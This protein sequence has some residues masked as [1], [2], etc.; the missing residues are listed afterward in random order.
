[1]ITTGQEYVCTACGQHIIFQFEGEE[2]VATKEYTEGLKCPLCREVNS[3][4]R[5]S[6]R[7]SGQSHLSYGPCARCSSQTEYFN[8]PNGTHTVYCPECSRAYSSSS[9]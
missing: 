9:Y 1:M 8:L 4:K 5:G 2:A 6:G 7:D 3:L